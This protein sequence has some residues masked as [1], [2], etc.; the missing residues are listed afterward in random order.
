[1]PRVQESIEYHYGQRHL[2][3]HAEI[4]LQQWY[5]TQAHRAHQ[6]SLHEIGHF[7]PI[8]HKG[9]SY[10][11]GPCLYVGLLFAYRCIRIH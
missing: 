3:G 6:Q 8:V 7:K 5:R 2:K 1:M 11:E 9:E 10:L 4:I